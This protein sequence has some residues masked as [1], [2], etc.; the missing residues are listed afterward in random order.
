MHDTHVMDV[1]RVETAVNAAEHHRATLGVGGRDD[2]SLRLVRAVKVEGEERL[3]EE[4]SSIHLQNHRSGTCVGT[5]RGSTV[6]NGS[7]GGRGARHGQANTLP[8]MT[9]TL[10]C[11]SM[12]VLSRHARRGRRVD[13]P[14]QFRD[15]ALGLEG[16]ASGGWRPQHARAPP[17]VEE[18]ICIPYRPRRWLDI[19]VRGFRR[20]W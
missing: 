19:R 17:R 1:A 15:G 8:P 6:N 4:A 13:R 7:T 14:S 12:L 10:L 9:V 16:G 2:G 3:L 5:R 18:I 11:R 20:T